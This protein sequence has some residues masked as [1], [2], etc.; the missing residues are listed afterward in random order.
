MIFRMLRSG[1]R[2]FEIRRKVAKSSILSQ[3]VKLATTYQ[4]I[5]IH[6]PGFG[7]QDK[8]KDFHN[9]KTFLIMNFSAVRFENFFY[10]AFF[11]S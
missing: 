11:Q 6:V 2:I 5:Q 8:L 1:P 9:T 7:Y 10:S 4:K 3:N